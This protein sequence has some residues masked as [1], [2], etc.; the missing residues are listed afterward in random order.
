M[1]NFLI[2]IGSPDPKQITRKPPREPPEKRLSLF[3][4]GLRI[5]YL[6]YENYHPDHIFHHVGGTHLLLLI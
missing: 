5:Q 6:Q 1:I 3:F 4:S 2:Y